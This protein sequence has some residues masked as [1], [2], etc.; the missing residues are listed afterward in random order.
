MLKTFSSFSSLY[1]VSAFSATC[2]SL[3]KQRAVC[4]LQSLDA[5][6][7]H[8]NGRTSAFYPQEQK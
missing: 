6:S 8:L 5:F 4:S 7:F 2:G 3:K 1:M